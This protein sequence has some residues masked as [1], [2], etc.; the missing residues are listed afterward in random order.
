MNAHPSLGV[1]L[2]DALAEALPTRSA[3]ARSTAALLNNPGCVRRAVLDAARVDLGGIASTLGAP[4]QFGQSP[5]ALGQGNRFEQRVKAEGYSALVAAVNELLGI[6]D[7]IETLRTVNLERVATGGR[8]LIEARAE[9]T[10]DVLVAIATGAVDAPHVVDH[11][12]TTL[13][14]GGT[15][16]FLEQDALAFREG[17]HLRICEVKG[18]PIID[19]C[20]D[21]E[22]V[23]AA[24]RQTAVYLASI[25][26]TLA[27]RALDSAVVS[28]EVILICP[29]NFSVQPVAARV[30]VSRELRA[31]RRQLR[32]RAEIG[33]IVEA[34]EAAAMAAGVDIRSLASRLNTNNEDSGRTVSQLVAQ[35]P[36][37]YA[38]QCLSDCDLG[39]H[40]RNCA[41]AA[42]DPRRLG[43]AV[44]DLVPANVSVS[45]VIS[46]AD[47]PMPRP[48][49]VEVA[50]LLSS[51]RRAVEEARR[52]AS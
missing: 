32:R 17:E 33:A 37:A 43:G 34:V 27:A 36:Y 2:L 19:G 14:V 10:A 21:P 29:R 49:V 12:V 42:D 35:L 8:S 26:D 22:Q 40:C 52:I 39:R 4:I 51:A 50:V 9:A 16:V 47:D 44:V 48:D 18:F 6:F 38:P 30:D 11:G 5:F 24:A 45:G 20:A 46:L 23:G 13:E 7:D 1:P 3:T 28:D 31:L 25:Q 41:E 15:R